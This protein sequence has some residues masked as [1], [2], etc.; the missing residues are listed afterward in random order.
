MSSTTLFLLQEKKEKERKETKKVKLGS[1]FSVKKKNKE[2]RGS[3]QPF[4]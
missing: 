3:G 4:F 1:S 2:V